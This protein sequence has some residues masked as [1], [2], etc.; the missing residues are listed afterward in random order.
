MNIFVIIVCLIFP[1]ESL[2]QEDRED[3]P[4]TEQDFRDKC[5]QACGRG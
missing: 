3:P 1:C 2:L 5:E 4:M